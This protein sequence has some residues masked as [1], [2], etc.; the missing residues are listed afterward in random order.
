MLNKDKLEQLMSILGELTDEQKAILTEALE[1]RIPEKEIF[2]KLSVDESKCTHC[3]KCLKV[4]K[5]DIKK[6][7]DR[8]C[9][10]CGECKKC[11]SAINAECGLRNL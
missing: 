8:E 6:V 11:C 1:K 4:C 10:H 2:E 9:V 3:G 5:T 7:G